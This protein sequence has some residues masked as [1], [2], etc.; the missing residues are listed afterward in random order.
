MDKC[1][2]V[3]LEVFLVMHFFGTGTLVYHKESL[4]TSTG[5]R[6]ALASSLET[7]RAVLLAGVGT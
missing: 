6:E 7:A 1:I 2:G 3:I 4:G 5:K